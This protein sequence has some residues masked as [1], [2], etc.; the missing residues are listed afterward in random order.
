MGGKFDG[1]YMN[2]IS[3]KHDEWEEENQRKRKSYTKGRS[4]TTRDCKESTG[5][6]GNGKSLTLSSQIKLKLFTDCGISRSKKYIYWDLE[7]AEIEG[8]DEAQP[9]KCS[10]MIYYFIFFTLLLLLNMAQKVPG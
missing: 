9:T 3:N 2:R 4:Q 7:P 10:Q 1:M 8:R 6:S 5:N